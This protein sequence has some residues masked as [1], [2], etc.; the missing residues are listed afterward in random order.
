[1][2]TSSSGIK[3]V[4]L[5]A[6]YGNNVR[7]SVCSFPDQIADSLISAR[8]KNQQGQEIPGAV[9]DKEATEKNEKWRVSHAAAKADVDR[10]MESS[11]A[12]AIAANKR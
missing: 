10:R 2:D 11:V 1:M 3:V 9:L 5:N 7:G 12:A 6:D 8:I 4:K